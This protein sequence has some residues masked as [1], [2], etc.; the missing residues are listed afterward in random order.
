MTPISWMVCRG[1]IVICGILAGFGLALADPPDSAPSTEQM[2]QQLKPRNASRGIVIGGTLAPAA[3]PSIDLAVSFEFNSARLTTDAELLL[4]R[5]G[6]AL[7]SPALGNSHFRIA[8]NTDA[9]GG[10][11]YNLRLSDSRARAVKAYLVGR[12][13]IAADRLGTVG[14]GSS[15]LLDPQHPKSGVNRRVEIVNIGSGG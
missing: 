14:Y 8:G 11:D 15:H 1:L 12:H 7:Q 13:G 9:S 2:V 5:L 3:A 6:A 10:S 4:D